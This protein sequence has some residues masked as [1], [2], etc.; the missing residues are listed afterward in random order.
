MTWLS[1]QHEPWQEDLRAHVS[2]LTRIRRDNPAL[3]PSRYAVLG[4]HVEGASEM[5][6]FDENGETMSADRW[7][8]AGHRTLQYFAAETLHDGEPRNKIL[9]MIHGNET[10]IVVRLPRIPG[11]TRYRS[12]WSSEEESPQAERLTYSPGDTVTLTSTA[13]HLFGVDSDDEQVT[14]EAIDA[15][16][17]AVA[18]SDTPAQEPTDVATAGQEDT[19][20]Q[21]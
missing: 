8:N 18:E 2:A 14:D 12:L 20:T 10:P 7:Q 9:L 4:E 1:W 5:E 19:S 15:A 21:Q 3:R 6:W 17:L 16:A 11:V 13:M